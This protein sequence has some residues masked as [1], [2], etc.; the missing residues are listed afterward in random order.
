MTKKKIYLFSISVIVAFALLTAV[1]LFTIDYFVTKDKINSYLANNYSQLTTDGD[2]VYGNVI[3]GEYRVFLAGETRGTAKNYTAQLAFIKMLYKDYGVDRILM[4]LPHSCCV[5]LN[6]YLVTG[7]ETL[8]EEVFHSMPDHCYMKSQSY[9]EFFRQLKDFNDGLAQDKKLKLLGLEMEFSDT[10]IKNAIFILQQMISGVETTSDEINANWES[11]AALDAE[12]NYSNQTLSDIF[13]ALSTDLSLDKNIVY[14][15]LG[16]DAAD[17]HCVVNSLTESLASLSSG[18]NASQ[19]AQAKENLLYS[20]FK[21]FYDSEPQK[22][23]FGQFEARHVYLSTMNSAQAKR[24]LAQQLNSWAALQN[25]ICVIK[26]SYNG[27]YSA[28]FEKSREYSIGQ[29]MYEKEFNN[30]GGAA[31]SL[32]LFRLDGKDSIYA[33]QQIMVSGGGRRTTDYYQYVLLIEDSPSVK[34][35]TL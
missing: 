27:C 17:Y 33:S 30:Y 32:T 3:S 18:L 8:L 31:S 13:G 26:Y 1:L 34:E 5:L 24:S 28:D 16:S 15:A 20:N 14:A 29:T 9:T 6:D 22:S 23:Y 19:S 2:N 12:Q 10:S 11:L 21:I 35:L 4:E 7:D 25:K